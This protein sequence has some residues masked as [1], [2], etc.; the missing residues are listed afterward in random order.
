MGRSH[1]L[2]RDLL[3]PDPDD[4]GRNQLQ[5]SYQ[6]GGQVH[7]ADL[8]AVAE[9]Q[10]G[11]DQADSKRRE[12]LVNVV[13]L[14]IV[15]VANEEPEVERCREQHEEAEDDLLQIHAAPSRPLPVHGRRYRSDQTVSRHARTTT[16]EVPMYSTG[17]SMSL[18]RPFEK[19][20]MP[21]VMQAA[22][23]R[24]LLRG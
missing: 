15:D 10:H 14:R 2:R 3:G 7:C 21:W 22:S 6:T 13:H 12:P 18:L 1:T 4:D 23:A 5:I 20:Q 17:A 9:L 11:G 16:H 24:V 19:A 8:C